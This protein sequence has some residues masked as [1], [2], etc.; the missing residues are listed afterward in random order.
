MGKEKRLVNVCDDCGEIISY[1]PYHCEQ[2]DKELCKKC[3]TVIKCRIDED[4]YSSSYYGFNIVSKDKNVYYDE[5]ELCNE[6]KSNTTILNISRER[7][8]NE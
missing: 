6:C 7:M 4:K 1:S 8:N 5:Y 2:C 3:I